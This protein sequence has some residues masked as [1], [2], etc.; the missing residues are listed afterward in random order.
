MIA[1]NLELGRPYEIWKLYSSD[2]VLT[3]YTYVASC[4]DALGMFDGPASSFICSLSSQNG[5]GSW[6]LC[7][8]INDS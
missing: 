2:L 7:K 6:L 5:F 8:R 4:S 1:S 3:S